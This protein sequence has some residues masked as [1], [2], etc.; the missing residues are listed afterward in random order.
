MIHLRTVFTTQ[1]GL[2]RPSLVRDLVDAIK[3]GAPIPPIELIEAAD[4]RQLIY[5]G[6]HRAVAYWLAGCPVLADGEFYTVEGRWLPRCEL[7]RRR[8]SVPVFAAEAVYILNGL[9]TRTAVPLPSRD[10]KVVEAAQR[11][12][13]ARK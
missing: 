13:R 9:P 12:L 1:A 7:G 8:A 4:G 5:N 3:A 10:E 6:H 2:R 11:A